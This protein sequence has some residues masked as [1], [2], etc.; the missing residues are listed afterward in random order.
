MGPGLW[1]LGGSAQ[2]F[3]GQGQ[4]QG[5]GQGPGPGPGPMVSWESQ[6]VGEEHGRRPWGWPQ[7]PTSD[8][9]IPGWEEGN[10][11]PGTIP[12]SSTFV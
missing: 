5:P 3:Q 1:G 10:W 7:D 9:T 12:T 6:R 8:T 11:S 2:A 4:G